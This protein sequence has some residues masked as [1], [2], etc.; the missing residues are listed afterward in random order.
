M[1]N[2]VALKAAALKPGFVTEVA[3]DRVVDPKKMVQPY[4]ANG[5]SATGAA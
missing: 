1:D 5:A 2:D 3:F 4:V